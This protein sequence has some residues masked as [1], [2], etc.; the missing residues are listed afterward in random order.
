MEVVG[1]DGLLFVDEPCSIEAY[2]HSI[3]SWRFQLSSSSLLYL[4]LSIAPLQV[5]SESQ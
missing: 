5:G 4:F 1:W 2:D 3:G